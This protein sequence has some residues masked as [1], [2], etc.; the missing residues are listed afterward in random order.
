MNISPT[1]T[2]HVVLDL[3]AWNESGS[4]ELSPKF[5]RRPVWKA[6]SKS[7]FI[8]SLLRG[9]PVPPIHIR[10][11]M[12]NKGA[13]REIIDGQ[14]RLRA[15]F[16]FVRGKYRLSRTLEAPWAGMAFK[17]LDVEQAERLM[18]YKFHAFEYDN[19][20]DATILE[21]FARINTYSVALS[22]Q[23]LRNGKYFGVFKTAMYEIAREH[24]EFWRSSR[25]FSEVGIARMQEVE[26]VSELSI[27]LMDGLQ[28]KKTSVDSFY[29]SL[30]DEWGR[31]PI[32][33]IS[34]KQKKPL[35]YLSRDETHKRFE[36]IISEISTS[37]GDVVSGAE[38]SRTPLFYTL[39][40]AV[41]HRLYGVPGLDL[42]TPLRPLDDNDRL[43]LR[44]AV[45]RLSELVNDKASSDDLGGWQR[46]FVHSAA[47]QTDNLG[48]RTERLT[49]L[50]DL[51]KLS[52]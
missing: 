16:D 48:P 3:V 26:F 13:Y 12:R 21:I 38:F 20:A 45:T 14:Q 52:A 47:R 28:D 32:S 23:E 2:T 39:F 33:W 25:L 49:I 42:A 36:A 46:S 31:D 9:F 29:S 41:A 15:V 24:L 34:G 37:L 7:Y 17:D 5:Q 35:R 22:R 10:L 1:P 6:A 50:W 30:D 27:L 44:A 43:S 4:L 8:D 40:G 18:M 11:G 51:A 19:V